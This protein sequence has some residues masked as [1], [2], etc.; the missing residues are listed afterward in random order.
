MRNIKEFGCYL[1]VSGGTTVCINVDGNDPVG[2]E[3]KTSYSFVH[4]WV[5]MN[6]C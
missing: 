6:G 4:E 2:K 3:G 5:R 1:E